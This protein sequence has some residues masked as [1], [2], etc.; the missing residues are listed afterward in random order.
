MNV[1]HLLPYSICFPLTEH[2]GRYDWV[3]RLAEEQV[4]QGHRV[5]IYSHPKSKIKDSSITFISIKKD[6]GDKLLNNRNLL[7]EALQNN[8]FE[9]FHS[10]FDYLHNQLAHETIRPIVFTQHF[11]TSEKILEQLKAFPAKNIWAVPPT[12]YQ[13]KIN[14]LYGIQTAEHIYHGIR[15]EDFP[16]R[17]QLQT[18]PWAQPTRNRFIFVGRMVPQKGAR[19][20][21][22]IALAS[23]I[24][25][26]LVGKIPSNSQ[27]YWNSFSH[28]IDG[29][30][31]RYLG[32]QSQS[33][34]ARLMGEATGLLFPLQGIESFG[35]TIV[36]AMA[37]GTPVIAYN[38]GALSELVVQ[39]K[40]GF[41][42]DTKEEFIK[43]LTK[44]STLKRKDCRK[45]AEQFDFYTM[46]QRY[47]K[48]YTSLLF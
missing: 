5:T 42:V 19:E 1:A 23:G 48:L 34:V 26:D 9:I 30:I 11:F 22:E 14:K 36:E 37:T 40:T 7:R 32:P 15:L 24:Q 44:V 45:Q 6:Y 25:L 16:F 2:N 35:Q 38:V 13:Y 47:E 39:G 27:S 10:H 33:E 20:V 28:H 21:V 31:I 3:L 8:S 4:K 41:L 43:A 29:K 17:A 46:V 18:E 12:K